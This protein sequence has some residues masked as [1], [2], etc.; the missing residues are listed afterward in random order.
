MDTKSEYVIVDAKVED[1]L[2]DFEGEEKN[3]FREELG[4]KKDDDGIDQL[5]KQAY[6]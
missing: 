4:G 3:V 1:D 6:L 2:K 5:I